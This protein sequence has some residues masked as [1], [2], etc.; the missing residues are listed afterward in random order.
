MKKFNRGLRLAQLEAQY[1]EQESAGQ[2]RLRKMKVTL[3]TINGQI[4]VRIR[5]RKAN[6]LQEEKRT[7]KQSSPQIVEQNNTIQERPWANL[8]ATNKLATK[9]MNLS[10][11][12]LVVIEGVKIVE[13]LPEDTK[14]E[15]EI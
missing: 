3:K 7:E 10:Y 6:E 14:E 1:R 2:L 15:D 5:V 9:G 13:I 4:W 12:A 11:I 8:F